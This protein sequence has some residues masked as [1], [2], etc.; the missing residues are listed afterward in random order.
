MTEARVLHASASLLLVDDDAGFI[1]VLSRILGDYPDQR[2]ATSGA[3]GLRLAREARPDLIFLDVEMPGLDGIAFCEQLKADPL[4]A[5]VPVIFVTSHSRVP[6]VVAG[7]KAGAKDF[8]TKPVN[9]TKLLALVAECLA[10]SPPGRRAHYEA[11]LGRLRMSE[12]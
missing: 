1:Q 7:F 9:R 8:V 2:F 6:V 5:D 3:D 4:L 11:A 10:R 12:Q